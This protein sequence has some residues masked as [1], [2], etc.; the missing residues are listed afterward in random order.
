MNVKVL[1]FA[2]LRGKAGVKEEILSIPH[3]A[4]VQ[5]LLDLIATRRP[6]IARHMGTV[7]V[8]INQ[9]FAYPEDVLSAGDEVALFPPVSGGAGVAPEHLAIS[10]E[11]FDMEQICSE[12]V[13]PQAGAVCSFTGSVRAE[14]QR[15]DPH[16]TSYLEYEAYVPMAEAKLAQIVDEMRSRWPTLIGIAL[17]QRTGRLEPGEPSVLVACSASHRD[18]GVFEAARY[19]IDRLKQI[20]PVWKKEVSPDG[21]TW[22]EGDYVPDE[23][24]RS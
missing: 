2:S 10:T 23:N 19:G 22:V 12:L 8:S 7:L 11:P 18:T 4:D 14:T 16:H 20:V 1:Y 9:E 17:V 15:G 21:E 24:D 5:T 13:T 3:D 6:D